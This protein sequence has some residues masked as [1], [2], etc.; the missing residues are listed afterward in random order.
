M[1]DHSKLIHRIN[2][3]RTDDDYTEENY[4]P[5]ELPRYVQDNP[6]YLQM[7]Q[8][9]NYYPKLNKQGEPVCYL[10]KNEK[11]GHTMVGD[12][13]MIPLLHCWNICRYSGLSWT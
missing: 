10:F 9:C 7:F 6:E 12:F 8:Q 4:D 1:G 2:A 5:D 11:S 13:Y 3:Q